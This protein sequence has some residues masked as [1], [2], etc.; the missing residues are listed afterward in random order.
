MILKG[1]QRDL[2]KAQ[3]TDIEKDFPTEL[4]EMLLVSSKVDMDRDCIR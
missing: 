3:E 4:T 2:S 1:I